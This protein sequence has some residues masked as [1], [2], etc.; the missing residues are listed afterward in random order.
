[1]SA[2]GRHGRPESPS[3]PPRF[4]LL[5]VRSGGGY[6]HLHAMRPHIGLWGGMRGRCCACLA[7][8]SRS[9]APLPPSAD[10]TQSEEGEEEG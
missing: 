9:P 3:G 7:P 1:M 2:V 4:R 8:P 5:A 10:Y 6:G